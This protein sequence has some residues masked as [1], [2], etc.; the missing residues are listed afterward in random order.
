MKM[1]TDQVL[2]YYYQF[3]TI[4]DYSSYNLFDLQNRREHLGSVLCKMRQEQV[5]RPI[6]QIVLQ[7]ISRLDKS[8]AWTELQLAE[9]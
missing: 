1:E 7:E 3:I 5:P 9:L 2:E 4:Q 6:R 8:S